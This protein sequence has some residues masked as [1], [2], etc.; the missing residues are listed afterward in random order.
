MARKNGFHRLM[1][2]ALCAPL[3]LGAA[4]TTQLTQAVDAQRALVAEQ[5][6]NA[7][8]LNDLG[9][10]LVE[11][12]RV[13][14]AEEAYRR[15]ME[16]DPGRPEPPYNLSLLLATERPREARRLLKTMLKEHPEHAWGHYHLGTLHQA[17]G[18]RGRALASYR[19][20]F[21]LDPS[22]SDPRRNPHVLD[23]TMATAAMLEAFA[24]IASSA[25]SQRLYVEPRH[26]TGL[27]LPP[28]TSAPEPM[29]EETKP[30][31]AEEAESAEEDEPAAGEEP[32][33]MTEETT[34]EVV[35]GPN[36]RRGRRRPKKE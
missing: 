3:L 7:G 19:E 9:N 30:E 17:K 28:L 31:M 8:A 1:V 32:D 14:E 25:T 36:V 33:E 26:I 5:P 4:S 16:I 23:N 22:L 12:R 15:A 13:E 2:A 20:A 11:M 21:R 6:G 27:L 29:A 35:E 18:N 24:M 10:L 34:E